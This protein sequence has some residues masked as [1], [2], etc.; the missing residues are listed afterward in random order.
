MFRNEKPITDPRQKAVRDRVR[1]SYNRLQ[2]LSTNSDDLQNAGQLPAPSSC[3]R[4]FDTAL[5]SILQ[6]SVFFYGATGSRCA[7]G[8]SARCRCT[9]ASRCPQAWR[10]LDDFISSAASPEESLRLLSKVPPEAAASY[11][12]A[13]ESQITAAP[14]MPDADARARH[15][16][17]AM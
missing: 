11:V 3:S 12:I 16:L 5:L 6:V 4:A 7:R 1:A 8:S 10:M 13:V 9:T 15:S 14:G 17:R 2:L